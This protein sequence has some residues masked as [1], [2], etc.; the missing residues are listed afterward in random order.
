MQNPNE[1]D[2][3]N[4][5]AL[6][7][8]T[9]EDWMAYLYR[10]LRGQAKADFQAHLEVCPRCQQDVAAWRGS[11]QNLDQWRFP[12]KQPVLGLA[13]PILKWGMAALF[14]IMVGYGIGRL[15]VAAS[16]VETLRAAIEKPM[17]SSLRTELREELGA[18][19]RQ[20]W[21]SSLRLAHIRLGDEVQRRL[22]QTAASAVA[23]STVETERLLAELA[24]NNAENRSDDQQLI[25]AALRQFEAQRVADLQSLRKELETV[26]VLTEDRLQEAQG[27]IFRLAAYTQPSL[28]EPEAADTLQP[29][30]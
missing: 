14:L 17:R 23:R 22:E 27:Q 7:H 18:Q 8:P 12:R 1:K 4:H 19:L 21:E 29:P 30:R 26:A 25:F 28:I 24:R 2:R 3:G 20:E 15:S 10:E 11:M 6:K 13:Q 9:P 5:D 16:N